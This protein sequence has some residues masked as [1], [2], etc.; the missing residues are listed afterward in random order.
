MKTTLILFLFITYYS[1]NASGLHDPN[2]DFFIKL[3]IDDKGYNNVV[4]RILGVSN[5]IMEKFSE[6]RTHELNKF[7]ERNNIE[8]LVQSLDKCENQFDQVMLKSR[9]IV[10]KEERFLED[11]GFQ[12]VDFIGLYFE[13]LHAFE[14][15]VKSKVKEALKIHDSLVDYRETL[16]RI[17]KERIETLLKFQ[18]NLDKVFESKL[19][20][21]EA[22]KSEASLHL[23]DMNAFLEF[24]YRI[25][26]P[27]IN[28]MHYIISQKENEIKKLEL[29]CCQLQLQNFIQSSTSVISKVR[30]Q[31]IETEEK[32]KL[33]KI[34]NMRSAFERR[35]TKFK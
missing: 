10:H 3:G 28:V 31:A 2:L 29:K 34:K 23:A 11:G 21:L 17:Q 13:K 30:F 4:D 25:R 9:N 6:W 19:K 33:V 27:L 5:H 32:A 12:D 8:E 20:V 18:L 16:L 35:L 7:I 15:D 22:K 24:L 26:S 1:I 14:S